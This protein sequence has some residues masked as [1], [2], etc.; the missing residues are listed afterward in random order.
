MAADVRS[1]Q[2]VGCVNRRWVSCMSQ[3]AS[4]QIK[5]MDTLLHK[6]NAATRDGV[7]SRALTLGAF[8]MQK[9]AQTERLSGPRPRILGVVTG[10]L[11]A[12]LATRPAE[13]HGDTY[14][15]RIGTN[16]VYARTHEFGRGA[17]PARPFIKPALQDKR[18]QQE[19]L[20]QLRI[21]IKRAFERTQ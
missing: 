16:V 17:I 4:F 9:W 5:G 13:K 1:I 15:A 20:N 6:M 3:I 19:V 10:R 11:R 12:S 18:N 21:H 2:A 7:I 8:N 14:I